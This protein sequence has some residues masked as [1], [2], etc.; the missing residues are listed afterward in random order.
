MTRL[1]LYVCALIVGFASVASAQRAD[2]TRRLNAIL[3]NDKCFNG[4]CDLS[5]GTT[6]GGVAIGGSG[7]PTTVN[8]LVGTADAG[9]SAEIAVG[10]TP[11]GE[12]GGTWASPTIDSGVVSFAEIAAGTA[13][14]AQVDGSAESDEITGLTD[15]Q[16][17]DTLTASASTTAAANDNDTSI[18]TTAFVQQELDDVDLLSDNCVLENDSTPIPD[19]CVGDGSDGGG[20][21]GGISYAEA[22][23]AVLA[24]F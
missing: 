23:A 3:A 22:A 20:G 10:T 13:A 14:D 19:S 7:A 21:G 9:L 12:L 18:A 2:D 6:V 16:I 5:A 15:A 4:P 24:G 8:Y 11:G 1:I 17:S